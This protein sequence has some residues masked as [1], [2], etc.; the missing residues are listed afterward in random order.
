[1]EFGLFFINEK[2]PGASDEKIFREALEQCRLADDFGFDVVWLGEHHFAPYGTMADTMVFAGAVAAVTSRIKIGS[3]CIVPPFGHPVR[4]AEQ[5]AMVDVM[6]GGRFLAGFGRGYQ[7]REFKGFG[8]P[9]NE[10]SARF[11]EATEII[12]G[13]LTHDTFSY[14]GQFWHVDNVQLFPRPLQ[15]PAPPIYIAASRTPESF[16]WIVE[17]GYRA[18]IGNPYTT[19]PG[20]KTQGEAASLLKQKQR[21]AGKPET[22]EHAWALHQNVLVHE[23][24]KQAAELFRDNWN[25]SNDYLVKYGKV[26]EAGEAV[27]DDYKHYAQHWDW[28]QAMDYDEMLKM[29][30]VLIGSPD[31]LVEK[32]TTMYHDRGIEKHIVWMNRGGCVNHD[33]VVRS[34]KLFA[35]EVI[36]RVK[37]LGSSPGGDGR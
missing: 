1:V 5:I 15:H 31:Q 12:D 22:L 35:E 8:V 2:P 36:P 7:Q 33:D 10:A 23:D 11:R 9:Q 18:L 6:S 25:V 21:E 29:S 16:E 24:P 27:P 4:I 30:G 17:K 32:L 3:A 14:E 20:V 28:L 34:M 13:L 19:D 26:V 37:H